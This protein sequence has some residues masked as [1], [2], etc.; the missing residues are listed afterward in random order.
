[1]N[2]NQIKGQTVMDKPTQQPAIDET[3][4]SYLKEDMGARTAKFLS[5]YL[6]KLPKYLQNFKNQIAE[7]NWSELH[8]EAH[9]LK[10]ASQYLGALPLG[11]ACYDLEQLSNRTPVDKQAVEQARLII[12]V[13]AKR[14][15]QELARL[16]D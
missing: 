3:E 16:I 10:G 14:V 5:L 6:D 15:E 12:E 2:R 4:F 1:M 13:E 11:E 8:R 9:S 7:N